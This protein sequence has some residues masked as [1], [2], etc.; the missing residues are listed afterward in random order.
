MLN[1]KTKNDLKVTNEKLL[2]IIN[3]HKCVFYVLQKK[4]LDTLFLI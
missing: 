1:N 3:F 4:K 2:C